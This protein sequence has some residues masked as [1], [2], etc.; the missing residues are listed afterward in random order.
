LTKVAGPV[1]VFAVGLWALRQGWGLW[2]DVQVDFGRELYVP[3]RLEAGDQLYADIAYFNGPI[4]P[5]FNALCF[6]IFGVGMSTLVG[7][8][9]AISGL[10][11]GLLYVLLARVS[12]RFSAAVAGAVFAAAFAFG[13]P[14]EY[15][16]YNYV[17]PYSH[18]IT[19]GLLLS[20]LALSCLARALLMR[21][22]GVREARRAS[23][24]RSGW[25]QAD[26]GPLLAAGL[27]SGLVWLTKVEIFA[28]L[29]GATILGIALD[30]F[31]RERKASETARNVGVYASGLL[32]LLALGFVTL[33]IAISSE[34]ARTALLGPWHS[35]FDS[36][37]SSLMFYRWVLGT[38]DLQHS[39]GLIGEWMVRYAACLLP[40][41]LISLACRGRLTKWLPPVAGLVFLALLVGYP[42][43]PDLAPQS[44]RPLPVVMPLMLVAAF[45]YLL[46]EHRSG[47]DVSASLLRMVLIFFGLGLQAKMFL[48]AQIYHYGFVLMM[49]STL[50][51]VVALVGWLPALVRQNSGSGLLFRMG[52]CA[53][54][55]WLALGVVEKSRLEFAKLVVPV[56]TGAD[57]LMADQRGR[58]MNLAIETL[59]RE[60]EP[61]ATL[62][63]LPEGVMLNYL[64]RTKNPTPYINFMPPELLI[65]GEDPMLAAFSEHPPDFVAL[66]HNRTDLYGFR[67]FGT[68]YAQRLFAWVTKN[69]VLVKT[70]GKPPLQDGTVFGITIL[71]HRSV[72]S[73]SLSG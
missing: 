58:F 12:D 9:I 60:L 5:Y 6:R 23:P 67:Y 70:I 38:L 48:N 33:T 28:A 17:T 22:G 7:A 63:V 8:N 29:F 42:A 73:S 43:S 30:H 3:W 57:S 69:Y 26:A 72:T 56:G 66:V 31:F 13:H 45:G 2:G 16:N 35:A 53:L 18:E 68:D 40:L 50:L 15:A 54:V 34:H 46:W 65:F 47:R 61:G 52:A 39:W 64:L 41:G 20:L 19:H 14:G 49:P 1:A 62:A 24:P 10:I 11:A 27:L 32:G 25:P 21:S 4:S 51:L 36:R 71:R 37:V 59:R 55:L 44:V